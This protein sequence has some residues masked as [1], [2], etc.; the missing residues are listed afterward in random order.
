MTDLGYKTEG[1]ALKIG[2][3]FCL[4]MLR[5]WLRSWQVQE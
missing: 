5:A 3:S 2:I 1:D 4:L